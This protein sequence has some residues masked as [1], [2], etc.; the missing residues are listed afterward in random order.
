MQPGLPQPKEVAASSI[1][2][3]KR[4]IRLELLE[5]QEKANREADQELK[6]R[7]AEL[8]R[9]EEHLFE[10]EKNLDRRQEML[11]KRD[12]DLVSA[13]SRLEHKQQE[14][15]L[16]MTQ[17]KQ[18]L[19]RLA[20]LSSE[21]AKSVLL[22]RIDSE[23]LQEKQQ[24]LMD[25]ERS[26]RLEAQK[27]A[28][29]ILINVIQ[30]CA[31]DTVVE[32]TVAVVQLPSDD[33]KGRLIGREGRNIR[34]IETLTGCDLI[35]D[36]TPEAV[37]ISCFDPVRRAIG[38][39]ALE[40]LISDGRIHPLRIE[41]A[42][43]HAQE[44]IETN[45]LNE[46]QRVVNEL[47]V[48]TLHPELVKTLG[49]LFYRTSYGQNVLQH[50]QEV[51]YIAGMIAAELGANVAVAR[52]GGLLHDVGK[53][54]DQ[55]QEGTHTQIGC[56]LARSYGE[57]E[58]IVNCIEAHHEDVVADSIEAV[59][60]KIADAISAARPGARRDTLDLYIKRL[61]KLEEI[62]QEFEGIKRS[63]VVQ[64]GREIRVMVEPD[65][66]DDL[67]ATR[68]ARDIANQIERELEYPGQIRVT[69]VREWR[70][71]EVAS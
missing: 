6:E 41:E 65:K 38:K 51:A 20:Q 63:F 12:Q 34:T 40:E 45:I 21:E 46:G 8:V 54:V 15:E 52:R 17:Q 69:V 31:V 22:E 4:V 7:R 33:M 43:T 56:E 42:V 18:E 58:W 5:D 28:Q 61:Q 16:L 44:K 25:A 57:S 1:E 27:Q 53:A 19:E 47:G 30:R 26:I 71:T 14:L 55:E 35:I 32:S 68:M 50:S 24:R 48:T 13:T 10:K 36:D 59:I 29:E 67:A 64:A 60:V 2:E 9:F 62:A 23:L 49:R 66:V 70:A 39:L 37:V 11:E 3:I